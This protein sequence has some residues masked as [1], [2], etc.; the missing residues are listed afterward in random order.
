MLKLWLRTR[1]SPEKEYRKGIF[2]TVWEHMTT[3]KK[4]FYTKYTGR[5]VNSTGTPARSEELTKNR[6]A[7]KAG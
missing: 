2:V 1:Y 4:K 5:T 6:E 3:V 7:R